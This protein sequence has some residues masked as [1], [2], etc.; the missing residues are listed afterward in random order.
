MVAGGPYASTADWRRRNGGTNLSLSPVVRY[1][2]DS[3]RY[4]PTAGPL[5]GASL[6]LELGGGYLPSREAVHGFARLDAERYFQLIGRSRFWLRAAMGTSFSPGGGSR[7]WERSWWLT[8]ADNL[9]GY[10]PGDA[11]FLIGTHY[12]VANAE[13]QLPLDPVLHLAVFEYMSAIGGMD[14]GGVFSS[15]SARNDGGTTVDGTVIDPGPWEAR[16]LTGVLGVN[17][18][19]GPILFRVH[20]GH[21]FGIGGVRTPALQSHQRWVTNITL[22][23]LFF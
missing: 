19:F 18:T 2:Y 12:Y 9:R 6:L 16:T 10:G 8:A 22:R 11:A 3:V 14:F 21:P 23:Y 13:L 4:H 15:W 5:D 17:A 20:F 1:G 7:L